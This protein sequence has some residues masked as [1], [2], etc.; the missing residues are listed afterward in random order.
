[1]SSSSGMANCANDGMA[2]FKNF[3]SL[4]LL[5]MSSSSRI[6]QPCRKP[7]TLQILRYLCCLIFASRVEYF[8]VCE[9]STC[10]RLS[11]TQQ[12][13]DDETPLTQMQKSL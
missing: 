11:Q 6:G 10:V 4:S 9:F 7:M 2:D 5:W 3:S 12:K 13:H 8:M 1:M